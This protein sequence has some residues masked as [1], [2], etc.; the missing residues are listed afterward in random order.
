VLSLAA[1]HLGPVYVPRILLREVDQLDEVVCSELG[2]IL[3]DTSTQQVLEAGNQRGALSFEDRLCLALARER[4]LRCVTNDRRLRSECR[5]QGIEI[6]W[7]LEMMLE[8]VEGG[9]LAGRNAIQIAE[10]IHQSNPQHIT[11]KI[12]ERFS[13]EVDRVEANRR[14]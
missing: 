6:V 8:L 3:L 11:M 2:F 9:F 4:D 12:V 5:S 10:R 1:R 7:G 14:R 13:L